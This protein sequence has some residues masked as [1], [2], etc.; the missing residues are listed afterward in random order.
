MKIFSLLICLSISVLSIAQSKTYESSDGKKFT[1]EIGKEESEIPN[2]WGVLVDASAVVPYYVT[3]NINVFLSFP[4]FYTKLD[5]VGFY[6]I[7]KELQVL[8]NVDYKRELESRSEAS[9]IGFGLQGSYLL[10]ESSETKRTKVRVGGGQKGLYQIDYEAKLPLT[11]TRRVEVLGGFSRQVTPL[12]GEFSA[13][14]LENL[15]AGVNELTLT[16]GVVN[17]LELGLS[18]RYLYKTYI[19]VDREPSKYVKESR[20]DAKLLIPIS[21][22]YDGK[23]GVGRLNTD[24]FKAGDYFGPVSQW[25]GLSLDYQN[26]SITPIGF[27][28]L[29]LGYNAGISYFPMLKNSPVHLQFG[30]TFGLASFQ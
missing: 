30:L 23:Y 15:P 9:F 5:L 6:Q 7:N 12:L 14:E 8:A 28:K 18:Y 22:S 17:Q 21:S 24:E 11:R 29:S 3:S 10:R 27:Y 25:M 1:V 4:S 13:A 19:R 2:K 16:R 26:Y 20:I